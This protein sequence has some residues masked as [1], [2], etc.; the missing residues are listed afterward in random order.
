MQ[1][2]ATA[3]SL[4]LPSLSSPKNQASSTGA[5]TSVPYGA[6]PMSPLTQAQGPAAN[7]LP[8]LLS[9]LSAIDEKLATLQQS[10]VDVVTFERQMDASRRR[11]DSLAEDVRQ[12]Q[13]DVTALKANADEARASLQ[14]KA[15]AA[16]LTR[17]NERLQELTG[18]VRGKTSEQFSQQLA[19]DLAA[20]HQR[21]DQ[22]F[23]SLNTKTSLTLFEEAQVRLDGLS[24][25]VKA[26]ADLGQFQQLRSEAQATQDQADR[27]QQILNEKADKSALGRTRENLQDLTNIV[28]G[29]ADAEMAMKLQ[30][31]VSVLEANAANMQQQLDK[32]TSLEAHTQ[33]RDEVTGLGTAVRMKAEGSV[34]RQLVA[35][36]QAASL[37]AD[38]LQ[39][40]LDGTRRDLQE[41]SQKVKRMGQ[42]QDELQELSVALATSK[43][44][45]D[46]V[47][48]LQTEML[49]QL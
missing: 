33:L 5:S 4:S 24:T 10:K 37:N 26:R 2:A 14:N 43:A 47:P 25:A 31:D 9:K 35:D 30:A 18:V 38:R 27:M 29:K 17:T 22:A 32:K 23:E 49:G 45:A 3:N 42:Q 44:D 8:K 21:L 16:A 34:A 6:T 7:F 36:M 12:L 28:R 13:A 40:V 20:A 19:A 39:Q 1:R 48:H 11:E 15:E 46:K 41:T